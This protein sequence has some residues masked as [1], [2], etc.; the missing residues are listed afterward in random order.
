MLIINKLLNPYII[1]LSVYDFWK[2]ISNYKYKFNSEKILLV[3]RSFLIKKLN[4]T[5]YN[6]SIYFK[7]KNG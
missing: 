4:K 3:K 1:M 5:T 7:I 2:I 6:E